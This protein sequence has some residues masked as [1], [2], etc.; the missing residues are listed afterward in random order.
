MTL[1]QLEAAYNQVSPQDRYGFVKKLKK[2]LKRNPEINDNNGHSLF[3]T[4]I[5]HHIENMAAERDTLRKLFNDRDDALLDGLDA[6]P[7]EYLTEY[8]NFNE[9]IADRIKYLELDIEQY[10]KELDKRKTYNGN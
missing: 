7:H 8:T 3:L 6:A 10:Q 5:Q 2:L 9:D 1:D 4:I